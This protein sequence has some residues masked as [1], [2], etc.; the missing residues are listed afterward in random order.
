MRGWI[1]A[2]TP[3]EETMKALLEIAATLKTINSTLHN[4]FAALKVRLE[5]IE[6]AIKHKK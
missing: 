3:E 5:N 4:E 1:M 6:T 2:D